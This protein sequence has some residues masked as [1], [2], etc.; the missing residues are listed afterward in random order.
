MFNNIQRS[1]SIFKAALKNKVETPTMHYSDL[2]AE[3]IRLEKCAKEFRN[4]YGPESICQQVDLIRDEI[5]N[6]KIIR[7]LTFLNM[8]ELTPIL[9]IFNFQSHKSLPL[10]FDEKVTLF[11][12]EKKIIREHIKNQK[13]DIIAIQATHDPWNNFYNEILQIIL[14]S[15]SY[16]ELGESQLVSPKGSLVFNYISDNCK[17]SQYPD[18]SFSEKCEESLK[19]V[20]FF[21]KKKI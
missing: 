21:I 20:R 16:K 4:I 18:Y 9:S 1:I 13:F 6:K 14:N 17:T 10:W 5:E 7:D 2:R 19:P 11:E 8:S 3:T 12:R 15:P